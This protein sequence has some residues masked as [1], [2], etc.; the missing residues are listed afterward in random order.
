MKIKDTGIE[1]NGGWGCL[2][3]IDMKGL[4]QE[5]TFKLKLKG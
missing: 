5:V 4:S 2:A 3:C 1:N